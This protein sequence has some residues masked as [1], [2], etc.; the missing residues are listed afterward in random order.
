MFGG[1]SSK[2]R[3]SL[4]IYCGKVRNVAYDATKYE[5]SLL[6]LMTEIGASAG[7]SLR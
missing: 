3:Q 6:F 4:L 1:L 5:V 2:P 7:R